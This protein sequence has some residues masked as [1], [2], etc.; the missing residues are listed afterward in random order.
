MIY[1]AIQLHNSDFDRHNRAG[2]TKP[3]V[4][5][6][7]CR[8]CKQAGHP[9]SECPEKPADKCFN[10]KEEGHTAVEC[11]NKRVFDYT[12]VDDLTAQDAWNKLL[13][14]DEARELEDVRSVC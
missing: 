4:F 8:I 3:R 9:A 14:A 7:E 11:K 6:G 5:K 10:C 2:C 12:E 1:P 13:E